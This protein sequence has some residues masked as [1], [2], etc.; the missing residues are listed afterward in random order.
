MKT[1]VL[2]PLILAIVL[3]SCHLLFRHF[4]VPDDFG[5][6]GKNFTFGFYRAGS[7]DDWKAIP[8]KYKGKELCAECHE[9]QYESNMASKH[10]IIQ[11]ENCHGP[12]MDHA[13]TEEPLTIDKSRGLCLRCHAA[14]PYPGSQRSE[15]PAIDPEE[16][17]VGM[18]CAE[19][20]NPHKPSLEDM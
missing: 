15:L 14:L 20:H 5:V 2:R 17:N 18:E 4:Y 9:E 6:N 1:H 8:V 13:E 3:V 16:H 7:I 10:S 19:C 11:C 12:A